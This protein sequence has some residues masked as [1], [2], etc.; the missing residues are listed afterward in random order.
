MHIKQYE[1]HKSTSLHYSVLH[2]ESEEE[3]IYMSHPSCSTHDSS[4]AVQRF[5]PGTFTAKGPGSIPGQGTKILQA[6]WWG[7]KK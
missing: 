7:Q 6:V 2:W 1:I 3:A 4:L 5:R